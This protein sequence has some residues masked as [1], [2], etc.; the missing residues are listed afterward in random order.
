MLGPLSAG[1][2]CH[3]VGE[4]PGG[5]VSPLPGWLPAGD[6]VVF[7]AV[8]PG[9]LWGP[10]LGP[11]AGV[12]CQGVARVGCLL[13]PYSWGSARLR[14]G[15]VKPGAPGSLWP[16]GVVVGVVVPPIWAHALV[17]GSVTRLLSMVPERP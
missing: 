6:R 12:R 13:L 4:A 15:Q 5:P 3:G 11:C 7:G 16:R 8:E 9:F 14:S 1:Q 2:V 17:G 10:G